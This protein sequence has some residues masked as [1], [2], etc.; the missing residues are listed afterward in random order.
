MKN[1]LAI[2]AMAALLLLSGCSQKDPAIDATNDGSTTR[3][4]TSVDVNDPSSTSGMDDGGIDQSGSQAGMDKAEQTLS[5]LEG[6]FQS[7]QFDFDKFNIRADMENKVKS[8]V[9]LAKAD[10]SSYNVKLEGN[11]DEWGS[12][13]YN[14]ALGLKRAKSTKDAM[15]ADGVNANRITMVSFGESNPVCTQQTKA[16]WSKNRRVD[17]KLLP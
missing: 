16:C 3:N 1:L 2:S 17:S 6:K 14:Y 7:I 11:C 12:D 9:M 15:V 10:A 5:G 8:N 13:E 4:V